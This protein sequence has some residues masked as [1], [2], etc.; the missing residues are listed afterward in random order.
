[1]QGERG[2]DRW[3]AARLEHIAKGSMGSSRQI[4]S[5]ANKSQFESGSSERSLGQ[6]SELK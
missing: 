2:K 1:M 5:E 3:V 6:K 4:Q